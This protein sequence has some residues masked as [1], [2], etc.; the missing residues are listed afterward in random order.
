MCRSTVATRL[1]RVE[2][3]E[4]KLLM[5]FAQKLAGKRNGRNRDTGLINPWSRSQLDNA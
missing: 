1:G 5:S 3:K 2:E 4:R